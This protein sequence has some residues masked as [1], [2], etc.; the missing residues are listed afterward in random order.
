[1]GDQRHAPAVLLLERRPVLMV[2]EAG[3]ASRSVWIGPKIRRRTP[4]AQLHSKSVSIRTRG[5]YML[6]KMREV[7]KI[8]EQTERQNIEI[9]FLVFKTI[10]V[11]RHSEGLQKEWIRCL[12][13]LFKINVA[14][15]DEF[16][17]KWIDEIFM[18]RLCSVVFPFLSRE[19]ILWFI[20]Q[21]KRCFGH[22]TR[23]P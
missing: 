8:S 11:Q 6:R 22:F 7:K 17:D 1:M 23:N 9:T 14:S 4:H 18:A 20:H 21:R 10:S 16:R 15:T 13:K 3:W 2:Q 19:Q 12:A 5:N